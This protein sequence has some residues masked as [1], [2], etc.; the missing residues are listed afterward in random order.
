[1]AEQNDTTSS[2]FTRWFLEY[3]PLYLISAAAVLVGVYVLSTGLAQEDGLQAELWLTALTEVYQLLLIAGAALL[4]RIGDRRPAVMLALLAVVYCGDLTFQNRVAAYLGVLGLAASL[5]WWTLLAGKLYLLTWALRLRASK[6]ALLV[7]LLGALGLAALPHLLE[8]KLLTAHVAEHVIVLFVFVLGSLGAW[9]RR[10]VESLDGELSSWGRT[11]LRRASAAT[12][13]LWA[14]LVLVHVVLWSLDHQLSPFLL[15]A[16]VGLLLAT[17]WVADELRAAL[18]LATALGAVALL[19]PSSLWLIALLAS[20]TAALRSYRRRS[21][22]CGESV[23]TAQP[24]PYRLPSTPPAPATAPPPWVLTSPGRA[25]RGRWMLLALCSA[26]LG[27][28]T[29]DWS[30]GAWLP[31][32]L[33]LDLSMTA[34][35][36]LLFFRWPVR[37]AVLPLLLLHGHRVAQSDLLPARGNAVGWGALIL[38]LGFLL[39]LVGLTINWLGRR[40]QPPSGGL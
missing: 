13:L 27:L 4:Y 18:L 2:W 40:R 12:W 32:L 10:Q 7:P 15:L 23:A 11:V 36:L 3:N 8:R 9:T 25:E 29:M 1:M 35:A 19:Q 28:W 38:G 33:W 16:A 24:H 22:L 21:Q 37:L 30:G 6:T 34:L 31:H 20:A 17:R 14:V 39:L 5:L 26:Y